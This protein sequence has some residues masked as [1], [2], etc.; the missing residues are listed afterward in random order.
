MINFYITLF[1]D[2]EWFMDVYCR[3]YP[4]DS[5]IMKAIEDNNADYA[6]VE[7]RYEKLPFA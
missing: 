7:K 4:M 2:D 5:E 3:R 1:K 6:V